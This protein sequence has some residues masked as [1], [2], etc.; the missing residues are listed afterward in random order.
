MPDLQAQLD[1][2]A[3]TYTLGRRRG[4]P[5]ANGPGRADPAVTLA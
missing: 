2:F 1:A 3:E 5:E 4:A